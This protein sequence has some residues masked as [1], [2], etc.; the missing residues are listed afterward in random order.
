MA[1]SITPAT[2]AVATTDAASAKPFA[3]VVITDPNA[4]QT[5][6]ATVSLSAAANGMLSDPNWSTD[7]STI[8]NGILTV[9]GSATAV[10]T[11]LDGLVFTP[12][13]NQVAAGAAVAT[14]VTAVIKDTAGE[15]ASA[16]STITATQVAASPTA[17]DTIV[18]DMSEDYADGNADFK[19][20]VNGQQVGGV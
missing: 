13:A 3:G 20:S 12:T 14:K 15:T 2:K 1:I 6:T 5:E 10:S 4:G 19:V 16:A 11:A 9:S 18:L 7:H 8:T 17:T